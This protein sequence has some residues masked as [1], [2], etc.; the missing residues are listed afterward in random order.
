MLAKGFAPKK[1]GRIPRSYSDWQRGREAEIRLQLRRTAENQWHRWASREDWPEAGEAAEA[2]FR[3]DPSNEEFLRRVMEARTKAGGIPTA[4]EAFHEFSSRDSEREWKPEAETTELLSR[5]RTI[6]AGSFDEG[7]GGAAREQAPLLGRDRKR[8]LLRRSLTEHPPRELQGV[9]VSGEA[10]IGK[11]RLIEEVLDG[12]RL[13]GHRVF[14]SESAELEQLIPLNPLI[15]VLKG[16]EAGEALRNL[17]EPWRTVLFG[18]MPGHFP[19]P[20]PI[21][22]ALEIQP[23]SVPRR[24][25]EAFYQLLI[26]FVGDGPV[27]LVLEDL[28][29][30][31]RTTLS[32]L[33]FL[34]R[35]WEEGNLQFLF[36][37][38][39]EEL[40]KN[41]T[42]RSFLENLQVQGGFLEMVTGIELGLGDLSSLVDQIVTDRVD[43][44]FIP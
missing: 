37:V 2:L 7:P 8:S 22:E 23:G 35:R 10:G 15:E 12:L 18:V 14:R 28:Q 24:L 31:D 39:E 11:T 16:P 26:S 34:A 36:S 25:F 33:E 1:K 19:G 5:I 32:V 40:R 41:Q 20:G 30:A 42:L 3:I 38:R 44:P 6:V 29:W 21:P 43:N 4:E 27:I 17:D 13:D 9:L